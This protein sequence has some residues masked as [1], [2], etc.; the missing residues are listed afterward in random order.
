MIKQEFDGELSQVIQHMQ[1]FVHQELSKLRQ[2]GQ[3]T[4]TVCFAS[5]LL[6]KIPLKTKS[7]LTT[8]RWLVIFITTVLEH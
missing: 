8:A 4:I 1:H 7:R 6:K 3:T 2:R 5:S